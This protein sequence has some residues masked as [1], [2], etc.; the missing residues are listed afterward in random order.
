VVLPF[1]LNGI[2][3]MIKAV[4]VP[5]V[6]G[7]VLNWALARDD[8][9][10]V[11]QTLIMMLVVGSVGSITSLSRG[12]IMFCVVPP[13]L[14][15]VVSENCS[16]WQRTIAA[17]G[18]LA[19]VVL[20][21]AVTTVATGLRAVAYERRRTV[22]SVTSAD[23]E[24]KDSRSL[25]LDYLGLFVER[26]GGLRELLAVAT[27]SRP[28]ERDAWQ[29]FAADD[30]GLVMA[31]AIEDTFGFVIENEGN[32]AFG[33]G[34]GFWGTFAFGGVVW[35]F[36]ASMALVLLLI[37]IE[38]AF[39]KRGQEAGGAVIASLLAFRMWGQPSWFDLSRFLAMIFVAFVLV[40]VAQ[41][42]GVRTLGPA[43]RPQR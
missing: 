12:Y 23:L 3:V 43:V 40:M 22:H 42:P 26:F 1:R 39:R 32:L 9:K 30:D 8:K 25:V 36:F 14:F 35:I 29:L 20:G 37:A 27:T 13:I 38:F 19:A 24:G 7:L 18:V 11:K 34:L 2:I 10:A 15:M 4:L 21:L 6:G 5:G 28:G 17:R 33:V 41:G 16:K 31:K